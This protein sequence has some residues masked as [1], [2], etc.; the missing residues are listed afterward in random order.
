MRTEHRRTGLSEYV[1]ILG[2][3]NHPNLGGLHQIVSNV[4]RKYCRTAG[5]WIVQE[6]DGG[7]AILYNCGT[8]GTIDKELSDFPDS[9]C[10]LPVNVLVL[11]VKA[12]SS[13][14]LW[15]GFGDN[16]VADSASAYVFV[17]T[18]AS[19]GGA[20]KTVP[21]FVTE[22]GSGL[23]LFWGLRGGHLTPIQQSS[24][25][26]LSLPSWFWVAPRSRGVR[27]HCL[28]T[29]TKKRGSQPTPRF[30]IW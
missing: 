22:P 5:G 20:S 4:S 29:R 21:V 6:F 25:N 26:G 13:V 11:L 2:R 10:G 16:N 8:P 23:G 3:H 7:L 27:S 30:R 12:L 9:P 28:T 24:K 19:L 17:R 14:L 1:R 15:A 18:G